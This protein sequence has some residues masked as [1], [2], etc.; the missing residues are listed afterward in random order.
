MTYVTTQEFNAHGNHPSSQKAPL[1]Y[2]G[3]ESVR[4]CDKCFD[5]LFEGEPPF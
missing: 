2:L 3:W 1:R 5:Q 4:A